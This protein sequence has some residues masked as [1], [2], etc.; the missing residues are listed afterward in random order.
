M[1]DKN[2]YKFKKEEK[3]IGENR[4]DSL[5]IEGKS[6][7]AFP[8]RVL[9]QKTELLL[10]SSI[11][12]LVSVPKKRIKSAVKRN[13][14]KRQIREAYRLNKHYLDAVTE[15]ID[16]NLDIAFVFVKE[17]LMEYSIIEKG[18]RKGLTEIANRLSC[19]KQV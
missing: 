7:V 16:H 13:R 15:S 6:F 3:V 17:E 10:P 5:F 4:I 9:Y 1:S 19:N 8:L 12:V 11:S 14:I 2:N 18:M